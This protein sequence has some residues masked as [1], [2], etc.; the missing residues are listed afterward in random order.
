MV[1]QCHNFT[2][3]ANLKMKDAGLIAATAVTQVS[4]ADKTHDVG[5]A[6]AYQ[7][8]AIVID[9][10][11]CEVASNDE[12]YVIQLEGSATSTFTTAYELAKKS[13]GA[14]EVIPGVTGVSNGLDTLPGRQVLYF[15]NVAQTASGE[16]AA[17]RYLRL[18]TVVAGTIAGGGGI[19]YVAHLVKLPS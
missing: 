10:T 7:R 17:M 13:L 4:S 6:G 18:R 19:N 2:L 12:L 5:A 11:A 14:L 8:G 9:V 3:D 15:D 1:H 16:Q